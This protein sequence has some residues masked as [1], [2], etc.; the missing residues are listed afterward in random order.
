MLFPFLL[1]SHSILNFRWKM[2]TLLFLHSAKHYGTVCIFQIASPELFVPASLP[3]CGVHPLG[4][5]ERI[6]ER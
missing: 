5:G 2:P 1:L 6:L 3:H 4:V